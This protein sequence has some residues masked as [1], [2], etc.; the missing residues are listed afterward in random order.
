MKNRVRWK[1]RRRGDTEKE[2]KEREREIRVKQRER[3]KSVNKRETR[4]SLTERGRGEESKIVVFYL[5][6]AHTES[7]LTKREGILYLFLFCSC[8]HH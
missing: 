7:C 1:E 4:R 2:N 3:G 5:R 6:V 8:Y